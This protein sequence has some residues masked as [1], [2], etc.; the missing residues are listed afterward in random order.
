MNESKE[1]IKKICD[2][3]LFYKNK[4]NFIELN[5]GNKEENLI[6]INNMFNCTSFEHP[7]AFY[8]D[9][10][11]DILYIYEHFEFNCSPAKKHSSK[12]KESFSKSNKLE[13]NVI[14]KRKDYEIISYIEQ[15]YSDN[16]V[17]HIGKDGDKYRDNYIKNFLYSFNKHNLQIAKYKKDCILK[18]GK[19]PKKIIISFVIEDV[20]IFGT[21]FKNGKDIGD[22][23]NPLVTKEFMEI[24]YQS[25]VDYLIFHSQ[26][27]RF[28]ISILDKKSITKEMLDNAIQLKEKE[29]Y[30]LPVAVKISAAKNI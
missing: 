27:T 22:R 6:I 29:F 28:L 24:L 17:F 5:I 19:E 1:E 3:I 25:D 2:R 11:L 18:I 26:D 20:T 8:Y 4:K 14:N 23:V 16:N 30:I 13:E 15:G 21:R 7:D 10:K 12:L 9:E